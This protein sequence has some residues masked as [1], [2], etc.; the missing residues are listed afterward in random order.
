MSE[1]TQNQNQQ[2]E[3][4]PEIEVQTMHRQAPKTG[5]KNFGNLQRAGQ[6]M[7]RTQPKRLGRIQNRQF[8]DSAEYVMSKDAQ[9]KDDA[10]IKES[11]FV[12]VS[13]NK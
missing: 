6:P 13:G 9:K 4:Q 3:Q 10:D 7:N 11:D 5:T 1:P 8:F 2:N 12:Q